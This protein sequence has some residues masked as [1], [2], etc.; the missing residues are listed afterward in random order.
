MVSVPKTTDEIF[1]D[2]L[3]LEFMETVTRNLIEL[4]V[5]FE[6]NKFEEIGRIAHDIKGTSGIFGLDQGTDIAKE[7]QFAARDEN[8][9][10]TRDLID[11]LNKYIKENN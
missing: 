3:R 1:M 9:E 4:E 6:E 2:E 5:L 7:L 11:R 8:R 10:K